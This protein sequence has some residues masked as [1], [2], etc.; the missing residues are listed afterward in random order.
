[1]LY[2]PRDL[3]TALV[4]QGNSVQLSKDEDGNVLYWVNVKGLTY[5]LTV[6]DLYALKDQGKLNAAGIVE[7][8]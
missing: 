7:R 5:R 8:A 6:Q 1:M 4:A 3:V 2:N